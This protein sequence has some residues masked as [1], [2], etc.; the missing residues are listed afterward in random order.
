MAMYDMNAK[1]RTGRTNRMLER[2]IVLACEGR[3]VYV[4]AADGRHV[5]TLETMLDALNPP[6]GHGIQIENAQLFP[7][8]NWEQVRLS[9]RAH[10]RC[11]VLID[12]WAIESRFIK[13]L[14][15]ATRYD[16]D[17]NPNDAPRDPD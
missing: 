17:T 13:L 2:A 15:E 12:H 5:I 7:D 10:P 4:V 3:A 11:I 6:R 14:Q 9:P 16:D 1:R 8:L